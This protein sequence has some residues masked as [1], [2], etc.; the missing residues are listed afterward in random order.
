MRSLVAWLLD[1]N[2]R[3]FGACCVAIA[4]PGRD[5]L[6]PGPARAFVEFLHRLYDSAGRPASRQVS[7][8]I[9]KRADLES[10]SH[11]TVSAAL[12]GKIPAWGKVQSIVIVLVDSSVD[13]WDLAA[14]LGRLNRLWLATRSTTATDE[15][16]AADEGDDRT[17]VV[18][19]PTEVAPSQRHNPSVPASEARRQSVVAD[20][21][22]IIGDLPDRNPHFTGRE[23]LLD[24]MRDQHRKDPNAPLVLFG[25]GGVGKTQLAREYADRNAGDYSVIWWV[26]ANQVEQARQSLVSLAQRL[27]LPQRR[28][29]ELTIAGLL[30]HLES[31]RLS[32]LLVFDGVEDEDIRRLIPSI[33]GNVIVTTRD[34]AWAHDSANAGLEVLDFDQSETVQFLRKRDAAMTGVQAAEL[35]RSLGRL[36]LALEQFAAVR[37]ASGL[38][39]EELLAGLEGPELFSAA[40]AEPA[41]YPHTV[42]VSLQLALGQL[43][44]ANPSAVQVFALFAWFGAEPVSVPLLRLGA[45]ADIPQGLQRTLGNPIQL[46]QAVQDINRYGLGRL[47]T[48]EQ[49]L[50]V[51][52]MVRLVLRH[53]LSPEER[54]RALLSVQAILTAADQGWPDDLAVLEMHRAMAPHVLPAGLIDSRHPAAVRAVHHQIRYRYLLG[55]YEDA[56]RLGEAAVT[57]WRDPAF[58]GPDHERVL[59]ATRE[60]ANALRSLGRY[61]QARELTA[62]AMRR[63]RNNPQYGEDHPYALDMTRSHAADLRIGGEYQKALDLDRATAARHVRRFGEDSERT[64]ASRHNLA[65]GLR[66]I[67]DFRGAEAIDRHELALHRERR[68]N[69]DRK[70][71][72]SIVALAEDLFGLGRYRDVLEV[73]YPAL[74][75]AERALRPGDLAILL[76]RRMVALAR[77]RLGEVTQAAEILRET[78]E[79]SVESFGANHEVA[80]AAT[81]SYANALRDR[82]RD[83][84]AFA[85]AVDA[86]NVYEQAFGHANPLT[87]AAQLNLAVILR[88]R[89]ELAQARRADDAAWRA[90]TS[91][92]GGRH[93]LTIVATINLA[94]DMA[95]DGDHEGALAMSVTA[96]NAARE[97]RGPRHSDTLVA[98]ANL[99]LDRAVNGARGAASV[100]PRIDEVLADL[101]RTLGPDHLAVRNAAAGV[102]LECDVEPPF[103]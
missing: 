25:L 15:E 85:F 5:R 99:A 83:G 100:G 97:V 38:S 93:P 80:L 63:L 40:T 6:P 31:Q 8:A 12:R 14:V 24:A 65:V 9:F 52:P 30:G 3:E 88:G 75:A 50:E 41:H 2:G 66:L 28:N 101:R 94:T 89:S 91:V 90:L 77:R 44:S 82:R 78:Y 1:E 49:R 55:D 34:P 54:E 60:W 17:Q 42:G 26:S 32:F 56:R 67:G 84:G 57:T 53:S 81:M 21:A 27:K 16:H 96:W 72:L 7:R 39:W 23:I 79:E 92:A 11:E 61:Q 10:V 45:N 19:S 64:L 76:A 48:K 98:A 4:L 46:R 43:R 37:V 29:A 74:Q 69:G 73:Q 35:T 70:T 59:L 68:G 102:R 33:G 71:L 22:P 36:P 47:H 18:D 87:L 58:L 103:L 20:V 86:V 62:D 95:L 51:Q 13:E